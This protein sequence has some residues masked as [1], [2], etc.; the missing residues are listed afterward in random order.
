MFKNEVIKEIYQ[1][2][3]AWKSEKDTIELKID[4]IKNYD[5]VILG[6][7]LIPDVNS[8]DNVYFK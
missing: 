5:A 3:D 4:G 1:T 7:E 8:V 2:A 6:S